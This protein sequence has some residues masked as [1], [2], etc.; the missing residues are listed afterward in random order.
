MGEARAGNTRTRLVP[1][2][3][4]IFRVST[5][6]AIDLEALPLD[7]STRPAL[8]LSKGHFLPFFIFPNTSPSG[9]LSGR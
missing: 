9:I 5:T 8:L 3:G 7:P 1:L 4:R 6:G 2:A